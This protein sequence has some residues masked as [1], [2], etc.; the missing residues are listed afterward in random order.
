VNQQSRCFIAR[1]SRVVLRDPL[2]SDADRWIHWQTHGEWRLYDAPWEG[3]HDALTKEQENRIRARFLERC[4]NLALPRT[5][6]II[7]TK[8]DKPLGWV[9][10]Y[11][12]ERFPDAWFV[13]INI[14]EDGYLSKG[15]GT[16]ALELWVDYLFSNSTIHRIGL[17]TWSFNTRMMHVAEKVG[18]VFEGAQRGMIRW[19][20]E[21]LDWVHFGIVRGKCTQQSSGHSARPEV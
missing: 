14:C 16:E 11:S 10:R 3:V 6:A 21:W 2:P 20:D 15:I 8:N 4:D 17:D 18:F 13:G 9:S 12:Q 5:R 7:C 1:G 19:Q